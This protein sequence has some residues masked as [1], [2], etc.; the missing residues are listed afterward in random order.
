MSG[1]FIIL[2]PEEAE[3]VRGPTAPGAAL[4]PVQLMG[5]AAFALPEAVLADPDHAR[6]RLFLEGLPRRA[7][8]AG[9]AE[10]DPPLQ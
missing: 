10:A 7:L 4:D 1:F 9:E 2:T 5:A 6:H 8:A 3:A